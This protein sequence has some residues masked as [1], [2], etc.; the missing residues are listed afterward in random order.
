[1]PTG[2]TAGIEDGTITTVKQFALICARAFGATIMQRDDPLNGELKIP[3]AS[4]FYKE[5]AEKSLKILN[6]FQSKTLDEQIQYV[7]DKNYESQMAAHES[8]NQLNE[9]EHAYKR[10]RDKVELWCPPSPDHAALKQFMLEQIDLCS[11][12]MPD[13]PKMP[14]RISREEATPLVYK[15]IADM[16]ENVSNYKKRYHEDVARTEERVKW[17]TALID[18]FKDDKNENES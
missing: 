10:L 15:E 12:S 14:K 7:I 5:L 11:G 18:C 3:Q 17:I 16:A 2:Y 8:Y 6:D 13:E 9:R 4:P 1:M